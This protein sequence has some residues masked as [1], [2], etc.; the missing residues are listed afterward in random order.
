MG[1]YDK[2]LILCIGV[3]FSGFLAFSCSLHFWSFQVRYHVDEVMVE[4]AHRRRQN[5]LKA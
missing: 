5:E 1:C 2:C 4:K 3:R